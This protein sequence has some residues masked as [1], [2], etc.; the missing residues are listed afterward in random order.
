MRTLQIEKTGF[1]SYFKNF[2]KA[3]WIIFA[4]CRRKINQDRNQ[5]VPS[6]CILAGVLTTLMSNKPDVLVAGIL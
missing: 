6:A 1:E 5:I 2:Q 3:G 4:I